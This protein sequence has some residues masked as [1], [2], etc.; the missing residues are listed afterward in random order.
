MNF[1]GSF[2]QA[3]TVLRLNNGSG[4]SLRSGH[5]SGSDRLL[6]SSLGR[7]LLSGRASDDSPFRIALVIASKVSLITLAS[8]LGAI[9]AANDVLRTES[10]VYECFSLDGCCVEISPGVSLSTSMVSR[11]NHAELLLLL[12]DIVPSAD[13]TRK[14][15]SVVRRLSRHGTPIG[16]V[17]AG[18]LIIAE[19]GLVTGGSCSVPWELAEAFREMHPTIRVNRQLYTLSDVVLTC[20]GRIAAFDMMLEIFRHHHGAAF[21]ASVA[22]AC[23]YSE[24]R[25][26]DSS[27]RLN[28]HE[29]LGLSSA[30]VIRAVEKMEA[31]LERPLSL[32]SLAAGIGG[33]QRRLE[34]QF[35]RH[36]GTT[37]RGFYL[38]LR[39][40]AAQRL[41]QRSQRPIFEVA[42]ATGFVSVSH[43]AKVYRTHFGRTPRQDRASLPQVLEDQASKAPYR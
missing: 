9:R 16:G 7:R 34:R 19:A 30:I 33:S 11:L 3:G 22:D 40:E 35:R 6:S 42:L 12:G 13:K 43:F 26:G 23:I 32:P 39:L 10:Y 38:R 28:L 15:S 27:Q 37:P 4:D 17:G 31:N 5:A 2:R 25:A 18:S 24:V 29:R 8:V 36:L 14:L 41:V 1:P 20:A 21:V